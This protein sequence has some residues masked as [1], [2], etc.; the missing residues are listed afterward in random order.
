MIHLFPTGNPHQSRDTSVSTAHS[1][2]EMGDV[3][4]RRAPE[5][6]NPIH[7]SRVDSVDSSPD[8]DRS[9]DA[10]NQPILLE[11][12]LVLNSPQISIPKTRPAVFKRNP[13]PKQN[14]FPVVSRNTNKTKSLNETAQHWLVLGFWTVLRP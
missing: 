8:T 9:E 2:G 3:A 7:Q 4:L 11:D 12:P 5:M 13:W 6:V 14:K 1:V 10:L